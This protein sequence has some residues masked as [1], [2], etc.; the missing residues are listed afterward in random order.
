MAKLTPSSKGSID[1]PGVGHA[2]GDAQE[3][4]S[5]AARQMKDSWQ[6]GVGNK[7]CE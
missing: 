7:K 3:T 1:G 2:T 4:V 5:I 6:V